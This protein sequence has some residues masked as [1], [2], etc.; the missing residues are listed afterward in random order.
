MPSNAAAAVNAARPNRPADAEQFEAALQRS[1]LHIGRLPMTDD[2]DLGLQVMKQGI[3]EAPPLKHAHRNVSE[4]GSSASKST[5]TSADADS[6]AAECQIPIITQAKQPEACFPNVTPQLQSRAANLY[7]NF[8]KLPGLNGLSPQTE[9]HAAARLDTKEEASL[10]HL[11]AQAA[12]VSF[13]P[14]VAE[15]SEDDIRISSRGTVEI[16]SGSV[17]WVMHRSVTRQ[18]VQQKGYTVKPVMYFYQ[19]NSVFCEDMGLLAD[20]MSFQQ[21]VREVMERTT[22][23]LMGIPMNP[24]RALRIIARGKFKESAGYIKIV[25]SAP[26]RMKAVVFGND[27]Q[28]AM[29]SAHPT[30]SQFTEDRHTLICQ[31]DDHQLHH[32]VR[33]VLMQDPRI[34]P[35]DA[36]RQIERTW[37]IDMNRGLPDGEANYSCMARVL[38]QLKMAMDKE[39]REAEADKRDP[40]DYEHLAKLPE[41]QKDLDFAPYIT[42]K[43]PMAVHV[44]R[45]RPGPICLSELHTYNLDATG[46]V[47]SS[48]SAAMRNAIRAGETEE[49]VRNVC[50][51]LCCAGILAHELGAMVPEVEGTPETSIARLFKQVSQCV[52][53][54]PDRLLKH[55]KPKELITIS[56]GFPG[57]PGVDKNVVS[58]AKYAGKDL[59]PCADRDFVSR[60][61]FRPTETPS[62]LCTPDSKVA[63]DMPT[64]VGTGMVPCEVPAIAPAARAAR[65]LAPTVFDPKGLPAADNS[66]IG[67]LTRM[68]ECL[69][70]GSDKDQSISALA[71]CVLDASEIRLQDKMD[72]NPVD[73]ERTRQLVSDSWKEFGVKSENAI[74]AA[75]SE[76]KAAKSLPKWDLW[77]IEAANSPQAKAIIN[78]GLFPP[79]ATV[80]ISR[81]W[82]HLN[83]EF[84]GSN[85][86]PEW[87]LMSEQQ[88]KLLEKVCQEAGDPTASSLLKR[89]HA[90]NEAVAGWIC[91]LMGLDNKSRSPLAGS[92]HGSNWFC[93]RFPDPP[94]LKTKGGHGNYI[95]RR[96]MLMA[97]NV[98]YVETGAWKGWV[99]Q[100][101]TWQRCFNSSGMVLW[102]VLQLEAHEIQSW[103][104]RPIRDQIALNCMLQTPGPFRDAFG[105]NL[106]LYAASVEKR[107]MQHVV[108]TIGYC[109]RGARRV[110]MLPSLI[111]ETQNNFG[112]HP[113]TGVA[114]GIGMV[115][116]GSTDCRSDVMQ[117]IMTLAKVA[118]TTK[119]SSAVHNTRAT[120]A[121]I[122]DHI[123]WSFHVSNDRLT[124]EVYQS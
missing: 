115:L 35:E 118:G 102:K 18:Q 26:A 3:A 67:P 84:A 80:N 25:T 110:G 52:I 93:L 89:L 47:S 73:T 53:E 116:A 9:T 50:A 109:A 45:Q 31:G 22:A 72:D 7:R 114:L 98:D 51:H 24:L 97:I 74:T 12:M 68:V 94:P 44:H 49:A 92:L 112:G 5:E 54:R 83:A 95:P 6:S 59:L 57:W 96:A 120:A 21:R 58:A 13:W 28:I 30:T 99:P 60:I 113:I 104:Q 61:G 86:K 17:S 43:T 10:N 69:R 36:A 85:S 63:V 79:S 66:H 64:V 77:Q 11:A 111:A 29:A 16:K 62:P 34:T 2:M 123:A 39:E 19:T 100:L 8:A 33:T 119:E 117:A 91:R 42:K 37:G 55:L 106:L 27:E 87:P 41:E 20:M 56:P 76:G 121:D 75:F 70:H 14:G 108:D 88:L 103:V 46:A 4:Q 1:T 81:A 122:I 65:L 71:Q 48:L 38:G 90:L 15:I 32:I 78:R 124:D 23:A 105:P 40:V 107:A 101:S 82:G